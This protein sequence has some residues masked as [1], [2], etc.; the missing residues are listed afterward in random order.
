MRRIAAG[1]A[2]FGLVGILGVKGAEYSTER[3]I[4]QTYETRQHMALMVVTAAERGDA[5]GMTRV[6]QAAFIGHLADAVVE[7][8]K[9]RDFFLTYAP[10]GDAVRGITWRNWYGALRALKA[11]IPHEIAAIDHLKRAIEMITPH[12][13]M[14]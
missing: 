12:D 9:D 11:T 10:G 7:M 3:I 5:L 8:R 14:A 13:P 1:I 2:A 4:N 6:E